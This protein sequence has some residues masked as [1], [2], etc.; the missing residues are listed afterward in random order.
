MGHGD[1]P[2]SSKVDIGWN[3]S[4]LR[5]KTQFSDCW[6]GVIQVRCLN[7]KRCSH[8][9][10]SGWWSQAWLR[11]KYVHVAVAQ[12]AHKQLMAHEVKLS[13]L[14]GG[15]CDSQE[16]ERGVECINHFTI[17]IDVRKVRHE[18]MNASVVEQSWWFRYCRIPPLWQMHDFSDTHSNLTRFVVDDF[19]PLEWST[20]LTWKCKGDDNL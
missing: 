1:I 19:T 11:W 5:N 3:H 4:E 14:D 2:E 15:Y 17:P 18:V 12:L 10:C 9:N 6:V 8:K 13:D 20:V 16:R 7:T